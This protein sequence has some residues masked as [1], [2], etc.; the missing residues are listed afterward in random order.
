MKYN[1]FSRKKNKQIN[2]NQMQKHPKTRKM[3]PTKRHVH[4]SHTNKKKLQ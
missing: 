3:Q 2:K 1:H 4:E